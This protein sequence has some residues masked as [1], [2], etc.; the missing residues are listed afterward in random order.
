MIEFKYEKIMQPNTVMHIVPRESYLN[1]EWPIYRENTCLE[2]YR[3]VFD[4]ISYYKGINYKIYKYEDVVMKEKEMKKVRVDC[5]GFNQLIDGEIYDFNGC[6]F[7]KNGKE[8]FN[9]PL[10]KC[11]TIK[12]FNDRFITQ[13]TEIKPDTKEQLKKELKETEEKLKSIRERMDNIE[14]ENYIFEAGKS[15]TYSKLIE[16]LNILDEDGAVNLCCTPSKKNTGT[17]INLHISNRKRIKR[18][19]KPYKLFKD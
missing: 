17:S 4:D 16:K 7:Y 10:H 12:E 15:I 3:V 18:N 8:M 2:P 9:E 5:T 14:E 11:Y 1:S 6:N 13:L 19:G